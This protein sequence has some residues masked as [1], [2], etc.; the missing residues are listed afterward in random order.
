MTI[1]VV[2]NNLSQDYA[3][4]VTKLALG[5]DKD[6]SIELYN[7]D[8]YKDQKKAI[9]IKASCGTR[10]TPFI[11]IYD[12]KELIKAFYGEDNSNKLENLEEW[13]KARNLV[14]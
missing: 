3:E 4:K 12:N 5:F 8:F 7:E 6:N 9:L 2:Y 14:P 11:S 10:M 13:M 1:K